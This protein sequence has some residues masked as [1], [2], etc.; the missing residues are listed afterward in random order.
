VDQATGD[1]TVTA[2]GS[3]ANAITAA[4]VASGAGL[5]WLSDGADRS[6]VASDTVG[7]ANITN[8]NT[9]TL[10]ILD[11][12]DQTFGV[13]LVIA[14][15]ITASNKTF[16]LTTGNQN[17]ALSLNSSTVG[18]V[19]RI[20]AAG[21]AAPGAV[22]L[23]DADAITGNL[24]VANLN[25]GTSASS[26]TFWRGDGTWAAAGGGDTVISPTQLAADTDNWN[27]T[28]LS[29]AT[30][31]RVDTDATIRYLSSITAP[32]G[33]AQRLRLM[34]ISANTLMLKD[35]AA[36]LGTAA[37]R[38]ILGG[39]DLP[40]FP[41][42][43]LDL[44]YDSTSSRWRALDPQAK[45]IPPRRFGWYGVRPSWASS[46]SDTGL[47][48]ASS[49]VSGTVA[50]NTFTAGDST[51][52]TPYLVQTTGTDTTGRAHMG[53]TAMGLLVGN[54]WYWRWASRINIV[55]LSDGTETFTYRNGLTD[56]T[57]GDAVDGVYL[58][59]T[60]SVNSGNFELVLRSNSS[61]TA[62]NCS[63]GPVANTWMDIAITIS[64]TRVE[65]YKD[66]VLIG[67][68]TTMTNLPSGSGRSTGVGALIVKSAGTTA[69]TAGLQSF[70]L[71][72]YKGVP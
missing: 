21:T 69:R 23:A 65:A 20:T 62:V 36:E 9:D 13:S 29:T 48:A 70:E 57:N 56:I 43:A 17:T 59:Y 14:S 33:G 55:T 18:Q 35:Q 22:D 45:V 30:V 39:Q 32:A 64:P 27:P 67:S 24:P 8:T 1:V 15:D 11:N 58:R 7:T 19:L 4:S 54:N 51:N 46:A 10:V 2:T 37:N 72:G 34:N 50:A 41:G 38:M 5:F 52:V 44:I 40:L 61:E 6:A 66:G 12:V 68:T 3:A 31:I 63:A 42:D 71:V 53:N 47:F 28:G 16:T 60:H 49:T 26:S 25:S